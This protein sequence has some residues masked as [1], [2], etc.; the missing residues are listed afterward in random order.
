MDQVSRWLEAF[1]GALARNDIDAAAE[2]FEADCYWRD[3][4]A[5]TWNIRTCEGRDEIKAML[6]AT[7]AATKPSA[8]SLK[9]FSENEGWFT[10]ETA[11]GRGIGHLRLN[12]G[13]C[14]TLLTTL[15]E[16]KGFEEQRST[17]KETPS[18]NP[19]VIIVGGG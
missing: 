5:F 7:L 18:D 11:V 17:G 13:K 2:L 4:V 10:F 19:Y 9:G 6:A 15:Q 12:G 1:A 3:L 16:L 14:W 8:F